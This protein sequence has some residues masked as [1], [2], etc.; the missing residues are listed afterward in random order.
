M[1]VHYTQT[2]RVAFLLLTTYRTV[3]SFLITLELFVEYACSEQNK[4]NFI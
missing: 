1:I 3:K 4:M 2:L